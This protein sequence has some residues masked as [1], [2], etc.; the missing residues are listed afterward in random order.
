MATSVLFFVSKSM[1]ASH[2]RLYEKICKTKSIKIPYFPILKLGLLR[3]TKYEFLCCSALGLIKW[4]VSIIG[5]QR[6]S[7]TVG[8]SLLCVTIAKE[9][10]LLEILQL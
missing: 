9:F 1:V 4:F 6:L 5:L 2:I 8:S 10:R 3:K 7:K